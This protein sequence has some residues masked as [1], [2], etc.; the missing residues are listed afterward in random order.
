MP[1]RIPKVGDPVYHH[2]RRHTITQLQDRPVLEGGAPA[3]VQL[4]VFESADQYA[5]EE[6]KTMRDGSVQAVKVP[7]FVVKGVASEL[8]WSEPDAAWYLPGRVLS[9]D[10]RTVYE[11]AF[12]TWPPAEIHL[13]ARA[14]LDAIDL[15]AVD[16]DRLVGVIKRMRMLHIAEAYDL[17]P[18]DGETKTGFVAR[19]DAAARDYA[20]KCLAHVAELRALRKEA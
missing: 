13:T 17:R 15:E 1:K 9:R 11:A 7:R 8:R 19:C 10:E 18:R 6:E 14:A 12:G 3:V 2:G 20:P 5:R 4:V 16:T